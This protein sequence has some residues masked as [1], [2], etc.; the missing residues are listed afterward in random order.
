MKGR[1]K[2]LLFWV[3][4]F[5]LSLAIFSL[6]SIREGRG[7][8]LV[9]PPWLDF[10][11]S[12]SLRKQRV[13]RKRLARNISKYKVSLSRK[14]FRFCAIRRGGEPPS[15]LVCVSRELDKTGWRGLPASARDL[16]PY[17]Y[18]GGESPVA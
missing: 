11:Q 9:L 2:P 7:T 10:E 8:P 1:K 13:G 4:D 16:G 15:F 14:A 18:L 3:K 17:K 12:L 6:G 5:G